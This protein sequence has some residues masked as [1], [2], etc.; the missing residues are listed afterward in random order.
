MRVLPHQA[1]AERQHQSHNLYLEAQPMCVCVC[2]YGMSIVP[3]IP[4]RGIVLGVPFHFLPDQEGFLCSLHPSSCT[5]VHFG[6]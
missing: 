3:Q 2:V 1:E 4:N 5:P 6:S